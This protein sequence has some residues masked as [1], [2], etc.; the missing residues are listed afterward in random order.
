MLL[1]YCIPSFILI[2]SLLFMLFIALHSLV[3]S[4]SPSLCNL[5]PPSIL[6]PAHFPTFLLF[7]FHPSFPLCSFALPTKW[8]AF[9]RSNHIYF[10]PFLFIHASI[11]TTSFYFITSH[12][13][14][15]TNNFTF[16][17]SLSF[18]H[19]LFNSASP[20][21]PSYPL[22]TFPLF[23][24]EY[25]IFIP[26]VNLPPN[27]PSSYDIFSLLGKFAGFNISLSC[28]DRG[29]VLLGCV[30]LGWVGLG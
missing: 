12:F 6:S 26:R 18:S 25:L 20:A 27:F 8:T 19:F 29:W 23:L 24:L 7:L 10:L 11:H 1:L 21:T 28:G 22:R 9:F 17:F 13:P 15:E 2:Y 3:P 5:L 16:F 4:I 30:L 14:Y